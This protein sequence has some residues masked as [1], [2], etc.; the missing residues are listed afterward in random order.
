MD[1]LVELF[2]KHRVSKVFLRDFRNWCIK[3]VECSGFLSLGKESEFL[4]GYD[5]VL[6]RFIKSI[7]EVLKK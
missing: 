5:E 4:N 1:S 7:D 2:R 3:D 6:K